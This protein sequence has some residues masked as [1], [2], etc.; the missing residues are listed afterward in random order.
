M[1][2]NLTNEEWASRVHLEGSSINV[3]Q[4]TAPSPSPSPT[5]IP[6][7]AEDSIRSPEAVAKY[8]DHTLL[9]LDAT[10]DQIHKL[11]EEAKQEQFAVRIHSF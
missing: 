7:P 2:A 11:C 8:I 3:L 4:P 1:A 6:S 10:E 5:S 9:K